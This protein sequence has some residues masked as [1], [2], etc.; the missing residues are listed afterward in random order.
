M[1][2]TLTTRVVRKVLDSLPDDADRNIDGQGR[3]ISTATPG[4]AII[5][6][7]DGT[8][9]RVSNPPRPTQVYA[10]QLRRLN[11]DVDLDA[12]SAIQIGL[13]RLLQGLPPFV[14]HN[15]AARLEN[16]DLQPRSFKLERVFFDHPRQ[17]DDL[18]PMPSACILCPGDRTYEHQD[19]S[20]PLLEDTADV[21]GEGTVLRKLSNVTCELDLTI[22]SAHKEERRGIVAGIEDAL[23]AEP[24]DDRGG[25]RLVLVDYYDRVA[26]YEL[27]RA[28]YPDDADTAQANQWIASFRIA[29][30]VDKVQLVAVGR[31]Q[32]PHLPVNAGTADIDC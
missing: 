11:A 7:D 19:L 1:A 22:W 3:L 8:L 18:E 6:N 25:R 31:M 9:S 2:K 20:T 26:R 24:N 4:V 14:Q 30:D 5:R 13:G 12:L 28:N 23:L 29:A 15:L 21:F 17:E 10:T 27:K 16:S 32:S